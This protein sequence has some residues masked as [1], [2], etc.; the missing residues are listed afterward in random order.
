MTHLRLV[1]DDL[2]GALDAAAQFVR[3]DRPISVFL[4]GKIPAPLPADFAVDAAT[5]DLD[6]E[7][8]ASVASRYARVFEPVDGAISFMKVDSFLRGHT[9]VQVAAALKELPF[10]HCIIAPAYPY[11]RRITRGGLQFTFRDGHWRHIGEHLHATLRSKGVDSVHMRPGDPVPEGVSI[12]DA[13]SEGELRRIVDAGKEVS[14]PVLWC[15]SSGLAAALAGAGVPAAGPKGRPLLGFFG[16]DHPATAAQLAACRDDVVRVPNGGPANA[17]LVSA[18]LSGAS[19]CLVGFDMPAGMDR[20]AA[21]GH[22]ARAIG[23]LAREIP[24][25]RSLVV[26][27]GET[28]RALC[29]SLGADRLSVIGQVIPGVAV[30]VMVGGLWNGLRVVS[31]AGSFGGE[32]FLRQLLA[33]DGSLGPGFSP[34]S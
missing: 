16:S 12:W 4:N 7:S 32:N 33:I 26:A 17:A 19:V 3:A 27:G 15:G 30:S 11:H 6:R 18:R 21:A 14:S 25:P 22:I 8:A 28:L 24:Q 23:E 1:A 5:R 9:G 34:S 20:P 29:A 31:K 2:T 10:R 13:D